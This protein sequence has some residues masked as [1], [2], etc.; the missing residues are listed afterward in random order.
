MI[1][2]D[3]ELSKFVLTV[4][5]HTLYLKQVLLLLRFINNDI[6]PFAYVRST[7]IFAVYALNRSPTTSMYRATRN[8][9]AYQ[10]TLFLR[11]APE[12]TR[13]HTNVGSNL[14]RPYWLHVKRCY[15]ATARIRFR[16]RFRPE[17]S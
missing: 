14:T 4:L 2:S 11:H 5:L 13:H 6:L 7:E 15:K 8:V 9:P 17:Q 12:S 3:K 1:W 16:F 10:I